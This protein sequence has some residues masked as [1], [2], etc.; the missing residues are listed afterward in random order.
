MW[1][2]QLSRIDLS[3]ATDSLFEG[4][5]EVWEDKIC[6]SPSISQTV[7]I[8]EGNGFLYHSAGYHCSAEDD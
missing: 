8:L 3:V 7:S 6:Y 2:A 1:R 4:S 5:E